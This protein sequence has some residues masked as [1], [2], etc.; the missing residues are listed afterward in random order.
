[1]GEGGRRGRPDL[2]GGGADGGRAGEAGGLGWLAG[3]R[4]LGGHLEACLAAVDRADLHVES[5]VQWRQEAP[6]EF[7]LVEQVEFL[8]VLTELSL[9]EGGTRV[10]PVLEVSG[11]VDSQY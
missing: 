10:G 7:L 6:T 5:Q 2:V 3:L 9:A 11:T 8:L 1:M 4:G